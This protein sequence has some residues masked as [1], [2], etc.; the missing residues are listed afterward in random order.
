[1][2]KQ[3]VLIESE[4]HRGKGSE[5]DPHRTVLQWFSLDGT[6]VVESDEFLDRRLHDLRQEALSRAATAQHEISRLRMAAAPGL[7]CGD[8]VYRVGTRTK[9]CV[10]T[11]VDDGA[12]VVCDWFVGKRLMRR[13]IKTSNLV[14]AVKVSC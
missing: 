2:A 10:R 6:L 12:S 7:K 14:V 3:V 4:T 13:R 8:I 11:V 9:M 5:D 1:M